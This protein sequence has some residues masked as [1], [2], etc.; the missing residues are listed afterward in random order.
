MSTADDRLAPGYQPDFDIDLAVGR[1]GELFVARIIDSL[2]DGT[3]EVKTDQLAARTGNVYLEYECLY[4]SGWRPSGLAT[5]KAGVWVMVAGNVAIAAP[6]SS[7][8]EVARRHWRSGAV[9]MNRGSHPTHGI[10]VPVGKYVW[11]L[12]QTTTS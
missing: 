12:I 6:T 2:K 7:V 4:R 1:T 3:A 11:D 5:T 9:K 10:K 8:Q